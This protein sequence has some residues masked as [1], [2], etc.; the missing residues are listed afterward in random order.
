MAAGTFTV[1]HFKGEQLIAADSVNASKDHLQ[2]RK[3]LD[4]G[5]SPTREQAGDVGFDLASLLVK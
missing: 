4:A 5:V 3:L 2:V 1:Y